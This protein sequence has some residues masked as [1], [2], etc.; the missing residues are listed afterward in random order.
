MRLVDVLT[1]FVILYM[2]PCVNLMLDQ[3]ASRSP[4]DT[5]SEAEAAAWRAL[6]RRHEG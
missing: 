5:H 3:V 4:A 2:Y 1:S 6:T